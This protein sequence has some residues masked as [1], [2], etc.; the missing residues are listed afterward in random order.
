M[1][2]LTRTKSYPENYSEDVVKVL[3]S[4]SF[5]KGK[6][7]KIMGS[8]ALRSQQYAGDY[9]G[10]ETVELN[11][12][13]KEAALNWLARRFK[14]M[15]KELSQMKNVYIG[16]IKAGVVEEW[17][18]IPKRAKIDGNKVE[19][20]NAAGSRHILDRLVKSGVITEGE[21]E[22]ARKYIKESPSPSD[23]VLAK[24]NI[25]FHIIRWTPE[26][27]SKG[28]KRLSDGRTFTLQDAFSSPGISKLDTIALVENNRYTDFS[29]IYQFKNDGEYLNYE[30]IDFVQSVK[31]NIIALEEEG[32]PFKI[33]KRKFSLAKHF[34]KKE[35]LKRFGIILNSDLGRLYVVLGDIGTLITL[36]QDHTRVPLDKVK[37]EIDQFKRRLSTIYTLEEYIKNEHEV[38]ADINRA[39][40]QPTRA[41]IA[42]ALTALADNLS[43]YLKE[44]AE[45]KLTGGR[46]EYKRFVIA[47]IV[48]LM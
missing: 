16:D 11:M 32:N 46:A 31:E 14:E 15:I 17:R 40:K 7:L 24:Q 35:D 29:V 13:T 27:V 43:D 22:G 28:Q 12:K 10:Y 8:S 38:L 21:A 23:L 34:N 48:G 33:L 44:A 45:T 47:P 20:Y 39:L 6:S 42:A 3:D 18:V 30:R 2:A 19:G 5:T 26:Q 1:E 41:R 25:K 9:D 37:F 4:M 36:L